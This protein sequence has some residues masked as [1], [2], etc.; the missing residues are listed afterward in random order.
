MI[1]KPSKSWGNSGP[2]QKS[3]TVSAW[4][5]LCYI[6]W[7]VNKFSFLGALAY[8]GLLFGGTQ[9]Q[10]QPYFYINAG[11]TGARNGSDWNNA[12]TS[13]PITYQRGATY[14]VG[15]GNYGLVVFGNVDTS[16]NL[17]TVKKATLADHGTNTGWQTSFANQAVLSSLGTASGYFVF[18]GQTGGGP[19]AWTNNFGFKIQEPTAN[20]GPAIH[21][22]GDDGWLV[23]TGPSGTIGNGS[24]YYCPYV[25]I[26]HVEVQGAGQNTDNGVGFG[27]VLGNDN[28]HNTLSYAWVHDTEVNPLVPQGNNDLIEFTYTGQFWPQPWVVQGIEHAETMWARTYAS[29][30]GYIQ[31]LTVRNNVFTHVSS[32]GGLILTAIG[33]NIYGNVFVYLP[34]DPTWSF[35]GN[36]VIGTQNPGYYTENVNIFNNTFIN[37]QD[38]SFNGPI[39]AFVQ[40]YFNP[41][42][43]FVTNNL[44]YGSMITDIGYE[45]V[46]GQDY[47]YYVSL[48][49][50]ATSRPLPSEPHGATNNTISNPF[51]NYPGLDFTLTSNTPPG[52]NLGAPYNID[53]NGNVRT[54]WTRGA[55]EFAGSPST[56]PVISISPLSLSFGAVSG[57]ATNN[58][59][60]QNVGGGTLAGTASVAAPFSIVSG[61]AYSL[62]ANQSQTVLV[63]Y[64][65]IG[66]DTATVT[67]TGG[68]GATATVSGQYVVSRPTAPN[69]SNVGVSSVSSNAALIFWT[70]DQSSSSTIQYGL[71]T[72]YGS[73]ISGANSVTNHQVALS[74]LTA[75]TLYHYVVESSNQSALVS[76][77][78]D[79]TFQ[80][81]QV[82]NPNVANGLVAHWTFE[83][84]VGNT[85]IDN[86]GFGNNATMVN[87][88]AL[89]AGQLGQAVALSGSN[90]L[91]VPSSPS[92]SMTTGIS[93][94]AWVQL[95]QAGAWQSILEKI[96]GLGTNA[97]PYCDYDVTTSDSGTGG[98]YA[99]MSVT[100]SGG[101]FN[102]ATSTNAVSYGA[103]HLLTGVYN[104][105]SV[106][107]YVDGSLAGSQPASG[108]I[109]S[110]GQPLFLGCNGA[111][112]DNVT[113][114]I[115]DVYIYNRG[116]SVAEV[117]SD[118]V[119]IMPPQQ[120]RLSSQ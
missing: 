90:Y 11:A 46:T 114:A 102:Y 96:V 28:D 85:V 53:P 84:H 45:G 108:A 16:T 30:D 95:S 109:Q 77:S 21:T 57:P 47:D 19:G 115:G 22:W 100:T 110:S 56:N 80:T 35:A 13:F 112:T 20:I 9:A 4:H 103:W 74:G 97:Y 2:R 42:N 7:S 39:L 68:G 55:Y 44:F 52:V 12:Y 58:F 70:T 120:V 116:L 27:V 54:T 25:T 91:T 67:F 79:M 8:L 61:G 31:N 60:V 86:S 32:T 5:A 14:Y 73:F 38:T 66:N 101:Q 94:S 40:T 33:V 89:V 62:G 34:G 78:V 6:G 15:T 106:M 49:V 105:S 3:K 64:T 26:R 99:Q 18:D 48:G 118:F 43:V 10:G 41:D 71:T 87:Q 82:G 29:V 111:W 83:H 69:I 92:L 63:S 65:P 24:S 107:I 75:A 76:T 59:T 81:A 37:C 104:G 1:I 98:F 50:Q 51:K 72:G 117:H 93:I 23:G 36:G 17:V 88:P 119:G 113:G